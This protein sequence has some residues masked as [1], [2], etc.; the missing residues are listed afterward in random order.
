MSYI[1][2]MIASRRETIEE[3]VELTP[4]LVNEFKDSLLE[5]TMSA[6]CEETEESYILVSEGANIEMTKAAKSKMKEFTAALKAY[7][8][9]L[10]SEDYDAA[11][12]HL[13]NANKSIVDLEKEIKDLDFTVGSA[14]FGFFAN[15]FISSLQM[16]IPN[17]ITTVFFVSG[18]KKSFKVSNELSDY[19]YDIDFD[20]PENAIAG[21]AKYVN[22]VSSNPE[23]KKSEIKYQ[24]SN[25]IN[26]I[27]SLVKSFREIKSVVKRYKEGD[28][29]KEALNL[30]RNKM[31]MICSDLKK[32]VSA[33]QKSLAKRMSDKE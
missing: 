27:I 1:D 4:E 19:L 31:L 23:V 32:L 26:S 6:V 2:D 18:V 3:N 9:A 28:V 25:I 5:M 16:L 14:I 33:L 8:K 15:S 11:K 29:S 22:A 12:S 24:I 13:D 30:Y 21:F 7:R 10:K 17:I 20:D